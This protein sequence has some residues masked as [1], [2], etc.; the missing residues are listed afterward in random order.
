MADD[1]RNERP[2]EDRLNRWLDTLSAAGRWMT[3]KRPVQQA[4][5]DESLGPAR[6]G[7]IRPPWIEYPGFESYDGFWRQS[8][9]AWM[10]YIWE[11]YYQSL[12]PGQQAEYLEHWKVPQSWLET[13]F[14]PAWWEIDQENDEPS[15]H[16]E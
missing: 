15:T 6:P 3:G 10:V 9:Q 11:P 8:G 5:P 12:D 2:T 7:E 14:N 4:P 1:R 13:R 16:S